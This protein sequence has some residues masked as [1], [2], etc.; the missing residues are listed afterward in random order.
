VPGAMRLSTLEL[1]ATS[2]R[3]TTDVA[4]TIAGSVVTSR[5]TRVQGVARRLTGDELGGDDARTDHGDRHRRSGRS[6]GII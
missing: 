2:S 3:E 5:L 6:A 4:T 1:A